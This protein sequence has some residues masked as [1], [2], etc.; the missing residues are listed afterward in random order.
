MSILNQ[1][2]M[3]KILKEE[4]DKRIMSFLDEVETKAK[5]Q[6]AKPGEVPLIQSAKGLKVFDGAGNRFTVADIKI[7]KDKTFIV[8]NVPDEGDVDLASPKQ[9]IK[10][11]GTTVDL[12]SQNLNEKEV[13]ENKKSE[14]ERD[15][16]LR[17]LNKKAD[18]KRQ[19]LDKSIPNYQEINGG[20]QIIVDRETFERAFTL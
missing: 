18:F 3:I 19:K 17:P 6:K 8:L 15:D 14:K 9:D 20:K 1:Q 2:L 4:Y 16:S 11:Y 12:K 5:Y 10:L 13:P 7:L